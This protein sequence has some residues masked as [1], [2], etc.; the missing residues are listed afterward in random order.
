[1][2][3]NQKFIWTIAFS[4]FYLVFLI[5]FSPLLTLRIY[6]LLSEVMSYDLY[7]ATLSPILALLVALP[8]TYLIYKVWMER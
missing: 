2:T 6:V 1:M 3:D 8:G 4:C 7:R 5:R